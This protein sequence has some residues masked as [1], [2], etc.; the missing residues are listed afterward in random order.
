MKKIILSFI[1]MALCVSVFAQ[2]EEPRVEHRDRGKQ[3]EKVAEGPIISKNL[4]LSFQG[5]SFGNTLEVFKKK[6]RQKGQ[7]LRY[8][9]GVSIRI[10]G[11][12]I[13]GYNIYDD[14]GIVYRL[15]AFHH[16]KS[17]DDAK[18]V[19]M[20][21]GDKFNRAYPNNMKDY[22]V[23]RDESGFINYEYVWKIFS[24]DKKYYLGSIC[25]NI[26]ELPI[27]SSVHYKVTIDYYDAYYSAIHDG[28]LQDIYDISE[29]TDYFCQKCFMIVDE[30]KLTFC[31][32][33]DGNQGVLFAYGQDKNEILECLAD[34]STDFTKRKNDISLYIGN[35]PFMR[36]DILCGTESCFRNVSQWD[37][38]AKQNR[39]HAELAKQQE[40]NQRQQTTQKQQYGFGDMLMEMIFSKDEINYH[41]SLGTYD[42][43]KGGMRGIMNSAGGNGGSYMDNLSPS[44]RAVI[45]EH[46][47]GK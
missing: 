11:H 4:H 40:T 14:K 46:D 9:S 31:V 23:F 3:V 29:F 18:N 21:I 19:C 33:K 17:L 41:K 39:Y 15:N 44:Q 5:V 28:F 34:D 25:M 37:W 42:F 6:L 36:S 22:Q 1:A 7:D 16:F 2:T 30:Y 38:R 32:E 35:I 26:L 20:D 47:N 10:G 24:N 45:H 12:K 13:F 27:S 43:L 8:N